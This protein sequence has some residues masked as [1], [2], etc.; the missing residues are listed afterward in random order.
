MANNKTDTKNEPAKKIKV[1][2]FSRAHGGFAY[3][4][5]EMAE[6]D[7]KRHG[8]VLSKIE[9]DIFAIFSNLLIKKARE[10]FEF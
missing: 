5:Y 2:A 10:I 3:T 8:K 9:P 1:L 4:E 7:L 6:A